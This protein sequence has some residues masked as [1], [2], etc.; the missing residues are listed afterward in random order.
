VSAAGASTGA[1]AVSAVVSEVSVFPPQATRAADTAKIAKNF[2][3][4]YRI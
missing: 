4:V 3:I 2:F 1:A